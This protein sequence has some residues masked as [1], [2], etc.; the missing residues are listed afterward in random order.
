MSELKVKVEKSENNIA[1]VEVTIDAKE[2]KAAYDRVFKKMSKNVSIPGFRKGKAPK[3]VIEKHVGVENVKVETLNELYNAN[4]V[5]IIQENDFDFAD[6]PSV[7]NFTY[8][9][10]EDF[11]CVFGCNL[12]VHSTLVSHP[13]KIANEMIIM[14]INLI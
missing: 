4:I 8:D 10:G 2:A 9:V 3:N 14:I 11:T 6:Q 1:K 5:K 13:V 7:E 12:S